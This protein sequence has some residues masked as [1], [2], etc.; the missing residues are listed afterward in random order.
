MLSLYA[1]YDAILLEQCYLKGV[2]PGMWK[3]EAEAVEALVFVEAEA[4]SGKRVSLP[5]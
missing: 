3:L 4:G 1:G 5:L 2:K